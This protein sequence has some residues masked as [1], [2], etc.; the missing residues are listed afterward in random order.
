MDEVTFG[1]IRELLARSASDA[2]LRSELLADPRTAISAGTG[3]SLPED[4]PLE[5][6][7]GPDGAI[8]LN[9]THD[10]IPMELLEYVAGGIPTSFGFPP[11]A[12]PVTLNPPVRT[13]AH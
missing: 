2:T 11:L 1:P 9:F 6:A 4:W 5:S 13:T 8:V 10:E 3:I 7:V 12:S